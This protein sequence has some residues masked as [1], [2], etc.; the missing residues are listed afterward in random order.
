MLSIQKRL[1]EYGFAHI[2]GREMKQLLISYGAAEEV[3]QE[4][5]KGKLHDGM[6]PDVL[7]SMTHR[8][9]EGESGINIRTFS[10]TCFYFN[11]RSLLT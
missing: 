8:T 10:T 4:M 2:P 9:L 5:E 11:I 3:L 1:H 6:P 7:P